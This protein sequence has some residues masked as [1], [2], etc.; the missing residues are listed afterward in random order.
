M[1]Y[2]HQA[3]QLTYSFFWL[4]LSFVSTLL[5]TSL[6]TEAQKRPIVTPDRVLVVV[7]TKSEDAVAITAHYIKRRKIPP[8]NVVRIACPTTEDCGSKEYEEQIKQPIKNFIE[9]KKLDVDYIVLTKGIPIRLKDGEFASYAVDSL[10]TLMDFTLIKSRTPNPYFGKSERFSHKKY[11][12]YLVTRLDGYTR[13]DCIRLIDNSLLAQER[14]GNFL[15]YTGVGYETGTYKLVNDAMRRAHAMLTSRGIKS[16]LDATSTFAGGKDL[17]G[18]FSWGSNDGNFNKKT[19][20]SL[21]FAPGAIAETAVSTSGRTF[22]DPKA[23]GQSLIADLIAQ[24]VTGCK[25]YVSEPYV[26]SIARADILFERYVSGYNLAESFYMASF[27]LNW[28]DVVIGDPL[29]AP[30]AEKLE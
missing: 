1:R 24:G 5:V 7:N 27:W 26:D 23:A 22:A 13:A 11:N 21:E 28:K 15:L 20:N 12:A 25:G 17:M 8:A 30:Y 10:L 16:T 6:P 4:T 29:C 2:L 9:S 18:Y 3:I 14:R 19:Y